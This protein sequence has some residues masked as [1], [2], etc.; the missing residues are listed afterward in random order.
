M[1]TKRDRHGF[2]G[3]PPPCSTFSL[4]ALSDDTLLTAYEVASCVRQAIPTVL[5]NPSFD[6]ITL[7]GGFKRS[8]AGSV[9]KHIAAGA[10]RRRRT[11]LNPEV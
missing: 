10:P 9:R 1:G 8:T 3:T 11:D 5:E 7:P 4:A 6:W 2:R